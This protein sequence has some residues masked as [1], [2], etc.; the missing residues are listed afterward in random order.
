MPPHILAVDKAFTPDRWIDASTA[1]HLYARG[2]VS[3]SLGETALV[4]RGGVNARTGVQSVLHVGSI[5]VVETKNWLVRDFNYAPLSSKGVFTR[6]HCLCAYCGDRFRHTDLS[7]DHV[8]PSC[9]GG[10]TSWTNLVT[11]CKPCNG[12]KGGRT[13]EEARMEL[14]YVPYRPNRFEWLIL[15]N[16]TILADQLEFLAHRVPKHSRIWTN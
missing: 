3:A 12:K 14:L 10:E 15:E 9:Q 1:M 13:P 4:L 8:K 6:D 7:L 11:S 5:L 16:R 2:A